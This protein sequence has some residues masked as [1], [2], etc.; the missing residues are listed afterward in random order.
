M[1]YSLLSRAIQIEISI[2][3]LFKYPSKGDIQTYHIKGVN[4]VSGLGKKRG[5]E[6]IKMHRIRP[7]KIFSNSFLS[8]RTAAPTYE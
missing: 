8:Y 3:I 5:Q 2:A 6:P 4:S 7:R 1:R